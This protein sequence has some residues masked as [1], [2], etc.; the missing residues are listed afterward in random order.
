MLQTDL[1]WSH[2]RWQP[3]AH[4]IT[5]NHDDAANHASA[6]AKASL[7]HKLAHACLIQELSAECLC[8]VGPQIVCGTCLNTSRS[9][10]KAQTPSDIHQSYMQTRTLKFVP[11]AS[12]C[13]TYRGARLPQ[14]T[15]VLLSEQKRSH[16][17]ISATG[18]MQDVLQGCIARHSANGQTKWQQ[19]TTIKVVMHYAWY[20]FAHF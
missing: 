14:S 10:R 16:K 12:E 15:C 7:V 8:K 1:Y 6:H 17:L 13:V 11:M 5:M 19:S 18:L 20:R 4:V 3:E 9:E 2:L